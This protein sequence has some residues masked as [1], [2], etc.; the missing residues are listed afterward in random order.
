MT[1]MKCSRRKML[2]RDVSKKSINECT[3]LDSLE[4]PM[5]MYRFSEPVVRVERKNTL[6][7]KQILRI[8]FQARSKLH[9]IF[10][11]T[12][13]TKRLRKFRYAFR[14]PVNLCWRLC[15]IFLRVR[16]FVIYK[17][18][19]A[20]CTG[21]GMV[22]KFMR[23]RTHQMDFFL[24]LISKCVQSWKI[25]R[26]RNPIWC[27]FSNFPVNLCWH[28]CWIFCI[29]NASKMSFLLRAPLFQHII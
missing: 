22:E 28:P 18:I 9:R 27:A 13:G 24:N 16:F 25:S 2:V 5:V 3:L 29:S 11:H 15:W 8:F 26:N 23:S 7:I 10:K 1:A 4:I 17:M 12:V 21:C 20:L 6:N 19:S 14:F